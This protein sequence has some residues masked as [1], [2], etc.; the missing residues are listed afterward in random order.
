MN[1]ALTGSS[2]LIGS[3]LLK[4]LCD[5]GHEVL[6][7]SSSH[8]SHKE[9]IFLYEELQSNQIS[10]K[11]DFIIHLASINSDLNESEIPLEIGLLNKV[12]DC[13]E[14]LNCKNIIF[15]STI[16]VYGENSFHSNF[17]DVDESFPKSPKCS[18]G[19]AKE[20][21]ENVLINLSNKKNLNYLIFRLPP[22]LIN[23]PKSNVGKLFQLIEKGLPIP[24]FYLGDLNQRSFLN[25]DLLRHVLREAIKRGV[26]SSSKILNLS[27]SEPISTNDLLR[28]FADSIN[29]KPKFIYLPNF[30]FKAMIKINR[31]Q[32]ILCRLF[33]SFYLSNAKLKEEF[34]IPKHF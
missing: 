28:R 2:G 6:C 31:L 8:S 18:Y 12:I 16:K 29:K 1:I 25:Y 27:D 17:I 33:G 30:L 19:I 20:H 7:I 4:D 15:F 10:F 11:A 24:S 21:C 5:L 14:N 32:L 9:N 23:H 22:V 26:I 3:Q 34:K 13:M